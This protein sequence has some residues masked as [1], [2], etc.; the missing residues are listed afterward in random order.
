MFMY[1][2]NHFKRYSSPEQKLIVSHL[3]QH[4]FFLHHLEIDISQK[5]IILFVRKYIKKTSLI[6]ET[7]S[8]STKIMP[9]NEDESASVDDGGEGSDAADT[10]SGGKRLTSTKRELRLHSPVGGEPLVFAWP[11][12]D[13]P[14]YS[15]SAE[16]LET[17]R[18]VL[19]Y[20]DYI[21]VIE[22]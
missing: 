12:V 11:L 9:S 8:S 13:T 14:K 7:D 16:I 5:I 20:F 19:L 21:P 6:E 22:W 1:L 4:S 17:I 18:L 10:S 2:Q 15:Q 3:Y